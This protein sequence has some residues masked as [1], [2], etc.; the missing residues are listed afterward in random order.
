M[1]FDAVVSKTFKPPLPKAKR[2]V[3]QIFVKFP[4]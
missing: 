2:K 1:A 3:K 4:F